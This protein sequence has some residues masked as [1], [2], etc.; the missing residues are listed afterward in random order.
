[1]KRLVY[2][3]FTLLYLSLQQSYAQPD[4][5]FNSHSLTFDEYLKKVSAGNLEFAANKFNVSIAEAKIESA[6]ALPDP[7]ISAGVTD[8]FEQNRRTGYEYSSEAGTTI[9]LGG[10]RR[11]RIGLAA[12]E[13]ELSLA[14]LDDY[15]RNLRAE[16][17]LIYLECLKHEQLFR[18]VLNS[19]RTMK[20]L[21]EADSMRFRLGSIME[22]DAIQSRLETGIIYNELIHSA[23]EWKNSL[24]SLAAMTGKLHA[25]TLIIPLGMVTDTCRIFSLE[26]LTEDGLNN[27]TDLLAAIRSKEVSQ[28]ALDLVR[29]E[30]KTDID[31]KM[32]ISGSHPADN[33][34]SAAKGISG[35]ISIPLKFSNIYKGDIKMSEALI[36][37]N[38]KQLE[39]VTL[40]IRTEIYQAWNLYHVYCR[41]VANFER[42]L[43]KSASDVMN[44]KIYSY[45][46]GETSLLE[47]LNARR[48]YNDIQ[49]AYYEA[50]FNRA[51]ALVNLEKAA[52]IWDLKF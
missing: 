40:Q 27:R 36:R 46:R 38:E 25:D 33:A 7:Y 47:V 17:A 6:K 13:H 28:K 18:V 35:G 34:L 41:Q 4:T 12:S 24:A 21:A 2:L 16:S 48:T 15:F 39:D 3:V 19:Y 42:G 50:I 49:T 8:N 52:G 23:T 31:L 51:S 11:A 10:K 22:I 32:G 30:R 45:K 5:L 9:E 20:Q 1:M 37:Q 44:G 29:S 26:K 43:L 14:L